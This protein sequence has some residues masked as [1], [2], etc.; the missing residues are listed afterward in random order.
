MKFRGV[1]KKITREDFKKLQQLEDSPENTS[2]TFEKSKKNHIKGV[3]VGNIIPKGILVNIVK[4]VIVRDLSH[5]IVIDLGLIVVR[6]LGLITDPDLVLAKS[7]LVVLFP[8]LIQI[9]IY[10]QKNQSKKIS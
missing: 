4:E 1:T 6:G 5:I 9:L 8:V 3:I 7:I 10:H 2:E